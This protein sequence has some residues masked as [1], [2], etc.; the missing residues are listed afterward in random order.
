MKPTQPLVAVQ[1][2][3]QA[4]AP[5]A[6]LTFE[7]APMLL[8]PCC[9]AQALGGGGGAP[10]T[11]LA[12][13]TGAPRADLRKHLALSSA[14]VQPTHAAVALHSAQHEARLPGAGAPMIVP[15]LFTPAC[16]AQVE[17]APSEP[18]MTSPSGVGESSRDFR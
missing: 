6:A 9:S 14:S 17:G 13:A 16:V 18:E 2:L 8:T 5:A 3:Q 1:K 7:I 10:D 15:M 4:P 12:S 11:A